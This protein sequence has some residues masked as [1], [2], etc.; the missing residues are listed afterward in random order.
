MP[1]TGPLPP[2]VP[3][4]QVG[5]TLERDVVIAPGPRDGTYRRRIDSGHPNFFDVPTDHTPGMLLIEAMRQAVM[6]TSRNPRLLPVSADVDF[7][8]FVELDQPAEVIVRATP[9]GF[10]CDVRQSGTVNVEGTWTAGGD[11]DE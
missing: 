11:G 4:R 1:P 8:R 7:H 10:R 2:A 9:T 6:A 5:R 3:P